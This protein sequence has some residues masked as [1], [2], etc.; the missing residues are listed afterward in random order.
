MNDQSLSPDI[1]H[2][3]QHIQQI[4]I[5]PTVLE[6]LST[7]L[8]LGWTA[9]SRVTDNQWIA[10]SV[11]DELGFGLGP[12]DQIPFED[13]FCKSV[14]NSGNLVVMDDAPNDETY[15]EHPIPKKFGFRAYLSFPITLPDG[16]FFG[17][18]CGL[19][20]ESKKMNT[21]SVRKMFKL[22]SDLIGYHVY[23]Q[24]ELAAQLNSGEVTVPEELP[25][26]LA[27]Q[28]N[29]ISSLEKNV[30]ETVQDLVAQNILIE[31]MRDDLQRYTSISSHQLQ[32][33]LRKIQVISSLILDREADTLDPKSRK[34]F[35]RITKSATRMR[36][37]ID[38]LISYTQTAFQHGHFKSSSLEELLLKASGS[39][40][41]E[42]ESTNA[43][44]ELNGEVNLNVNEAQFQMLL[45]Q[46]IGNSIKF[47]HP[48]RDP[49]IIIEG[50]QISHDF[51][52]ESVQALNRGYCQV[53]ITDNGQGFEPKSADEMFGLFRTIPGP[54]SKHG[55]G[56]GLAIAKKI[57]ENHQG[58]I[59]AH[60][61]PGEGARID[62]Y[63]PA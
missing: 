6:S 35:K 16:T 3:I 48:D 43:T 61:V 18:L 21:P 40:T 34:Y 4:N 14:R 33:P 2:D 19:D 5:I 54:G 47:A 52:S 12:G 50:R 11:K 22:Y 37:L 7:T 28:M 60:G 17:T 25:Q 53:S 49:K 32:E 10:C 15:C 62:I 63:V 30:V 9:V 56:A 51:S 8:G 29:F 39:L 20:P 59:Q 41:H 38:A 27:A 42:I 24:R 23:H 26:H 55:S 46:V 36:D 45:E 13:T 44:I 58:F 57:V 1:Q 31:R